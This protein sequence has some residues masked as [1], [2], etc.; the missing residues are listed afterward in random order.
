MSSSSHLCLLWLQLQLLPKRQPWLQSAQLQLQQRLQRHWPLQQLLELLLPPLP[1]PLLFSPQS[2]QQ[3]LQLQQLVLQRQQ[4]SLA[5]AP[6][7]AAWA[8]L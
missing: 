1:P 6:L 4:P 3:Q 5:A 2:L 8:S 7:C